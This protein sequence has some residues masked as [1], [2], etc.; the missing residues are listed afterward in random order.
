MEDFRVVLISMSFSKFIRL[1]K[2]LLLLVLIYIVNQIGV[3]GFE[4][5]VSWQGIYRLC[6]KYLLS[7]CVT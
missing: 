7:L 5:L 6:L 4:T 1:V 2:F 3:M